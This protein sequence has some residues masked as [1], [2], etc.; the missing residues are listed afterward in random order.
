[1]VCIVSVQTKFFRYEQHTSYTLRCLVDCFLSLRP[2]S[3]ETFGHARREQLLTFISCFMSTSSLN[4]T[5][6]TLPSPFF[7]KF[8]TNLSLTGN[9]EGSLFNIIY[10]NYFISFLVMFLLNLL[11]CFI[12]S[13]YFYR[14]FF[15]FPFF[16]FRVYKSLV[17]RP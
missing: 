8:G 9:G 12:L 11:N 15:S 1:M 14:A 5:H 13:G 10:L 4:F 16:L 6:R 7:F 3:L 17:N 2:F